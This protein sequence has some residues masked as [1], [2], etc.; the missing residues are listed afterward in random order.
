MGLRP[1][2]DKCIDASGAATFKM[3]DCIDTE[4]AYQDKR[5]N[6]A[7]M[8]LMAKLNVSE[9]AGLREK[10]K[11]WIAY[12]DSHCALAPDGGQGQRIDSASCFLG[13]TAKQA[14]ALDARLRRPVAQ[15]IFSVAASEAHISDSQVV[16]QSAAAPVPTNVGSNVATA[17][18]TSSTT[19]SSTSLGDGLKEGMAYADF[20]K[21]LLAQGWAPV[22]DRQC[23]ANV[24]GGD[25]KTSCATHPDATCKAC[26]VIPELS[27]CGSDGVCLTR[28]HNASSNKNLEVGT[29]GDTDDWNVHG[30]ES[31]ILVT[32][33]TVT[34]TASH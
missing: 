34:P 27:S 6:K 32:G 18:A 1:S 3:L 12:R 17:S 4:H 8:S 16:P 28:F 23:K 29:Y 21:A 20:H 24:V 31:R 25:Y 22:V 2:Y 13:E 15:T 30:G 9:Q 11:K 14:T 19:V 7:Y 26:D 10:E 33:W 5:L